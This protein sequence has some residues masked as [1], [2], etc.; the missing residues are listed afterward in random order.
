MFTANGIVLKPNCPARSIK[1]CL[2]GINTVSA[3]VIFGLRKL[4][5]ST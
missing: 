2:L 4:P 1:A 3:L 5:G